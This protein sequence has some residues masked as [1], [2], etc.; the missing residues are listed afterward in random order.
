MQDLL[1]NLLASVIAGAAVWLT[2]RLL[3]LRR[4]ARKQAFFGVRPGDEVLLYVARH[5]SS[6]RENSVHRADVASLIELA[7]VI[8][9]CGGIPALLA[10][11]EN[12]P[13]SGR[14]AEY[15]VGG[16]LT[17]PR[18]AAYLRS[19]FPGITFA[20]LPGKNEQ[21]PFS[22]GGKE[23]LRTADREEFVLL[24]RVQAPEPARPA[25]LLIGQTAESNLAA[26]RLLAERHREL[27][28][29]YPPGSTFCLLL[30]IGEPAAFGTDRVEIAADV[31]LA[32]Q[33]AAEPVAN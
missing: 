13:Q 6:H 31:T 21:L 1:I 20:Q 3:R 33:T 22:V 10:P 26:A 7:S 16:P 19:E 9:E 15:C 4:L 12:R 5:A 23:Y 17:N 8:R 29:T 11:D 27:T 25:F 32:A 30:R 2:Q 28:A 14:V 24:A 18:M